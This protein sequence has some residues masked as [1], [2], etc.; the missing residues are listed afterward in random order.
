MQEKMHNSYLPSPLEFLQGCI[1]LQTLK[2]FLKIMSAVEYILSYKHKQIPLEVA[3]EF[4]STC[5]L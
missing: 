4:I 1:H 2:H 5:L 3:T